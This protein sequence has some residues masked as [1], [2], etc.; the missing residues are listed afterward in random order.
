MVVAC[1]GGADSTALLRAMVAITGNVPA[2]LSWLVVAHFNHGW[3]GAESDGDQVFVEGLAKQLGVEC[4]IGRA[5]ASPSG[6]RRRDEATARDLRHRFLLGVARQTGARHIVLAH[7]AD[8]QA[9]TVL[10][11]ILRG[12]AV[13]GL[14]GMS[15]VRPVTPDVSLVRPLLRVRRAEILEYLRSIGQTYRDDSSNLDPTYT[16]NRI[17]HELLPQLQRDYNPQVVDALLNLAASAGDIRE[18]MGGRVETA[19]EACVKQI[20]ETSVSLDIDT[21]KQLSRTLRIE[22]IKYLWQRQGWPLQALTQS[23]WRL[24]D[25][26]VYAATA[27]YTLP[28][29]VRLQK[30]GGTFLLQRIP[31]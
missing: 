31:S 30:H 22:L 23:H 3:R 8:D 11:R 15:R 5:E 12:T 13:A 25:D 27:D 18:D 26:A 16:R 2:E 21:L 9:E 24:I 19:V 6:G 28:G 20:D 10:H 4:Q 29:H 14:A 17:R 1:S 7:T